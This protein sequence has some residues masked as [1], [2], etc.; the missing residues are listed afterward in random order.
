MAAWDCVAAMKDKF[1]GVLLEGAKSV[2]GAAGQLS[3]MAHG[4]QMAGACPDSSAIDAAGQS[5]ADT[6]PC[7][8]VRVRV[9]SEFK[10]NAF[11]REQGFHSFVPSCERVR[12]WSDRLRRAQV[13]LFP[14][15]VFC[16]FDLRDRVAIVKTPGVSEI[17]GI[18]R[19]PVAIDPAELAAVRLLMRAGVD[20]QPWPYLQVGKRV[21]VCAGPL[22][23][24]EGIVL[25]A[26]HAHRVVIS[27]TLLQ[28][29]V[30]TVVDP[31]WLEPAV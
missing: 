20:C 25:A 24:L 7:Y 12:K 11:L 22:A 6:A 4:T 30:A 18:G 31:G 3:A 10:A 19:Q 15:Y 27:V 23:G 28:R 14:G 16:S 1:R 29:S 5:L 9:R 21:R 17:V 13:A 2:N 8:A 26:K